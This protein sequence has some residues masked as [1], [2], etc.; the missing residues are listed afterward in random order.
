MFANSNSCV[1][2]FAEVVRI[3][4]ESGSNLEKR[5]HDGRTALALA[6]MS[7][8]FEIVEYLVL[9]GSDVNTSD[10]C[11]N[12]PLLHAINSGLCINSDIVTILLQAGANPNQSNNY[13]LTPLIT[14]I[15]RSSEHT[16]DGCDTVNNL[17]EHNC[18][19]NVYEYDSPICGENALHLAITRNQ[20]RIT[21]VLI[22]CGCD[23][24]AINQNGYTALARLALE[25]KTELFKLLIAAGADLKFSKKFWI[26]E[27]GLIR[28]SI[29]DEL[30]DLILHRINGNCFPTLKH[31]CRVRLRK[32][33]ERRADFVIKQITIPFSIRQYLLLM[34]L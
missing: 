4:V 3:L 11:G 22:R 7:N 30:R 14:A 28:N 20:H 24:N 31:L 13:G 18:N 1:I 12:T 8:Q 29:S 6:C 27:T 34:D 9:Q 23:V 19:L 15:R 21:E 16:L 10:N 17:I 33:L 2:L 26:D 5:D 25:G 32:W